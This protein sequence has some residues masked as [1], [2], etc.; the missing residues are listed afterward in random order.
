MGRYNLATLTREIYNSGLKFFT[1]KTLQDILNVKKETTFHYI[2]NK[3]LDAGIIVKVERG[4]YILND[5]HISNFALANFLYQPSYVSFE[6]ALN[7]YGILPQ[8]PYEVSSAT[9]KKPVKKE[10]QGRIFNYIHIKKELF[11]GYE[12]KK[13]FLIAT[14]EKALLDQ[15]YLYAKGYRSINLKEYYL[16][17]ISIKKLKEY[18]KKYPAKTRQFNKVMKELREYLSI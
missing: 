3:F 13:G 11:W 5:V 6:S 1:L 2:L 4:K 14:P 10:F 12:K 16:E 7:F 9:P 15:L 8:F 18:L 17:R